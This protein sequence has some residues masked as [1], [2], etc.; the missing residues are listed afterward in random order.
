MKNLSWSRIGGWAR[1]FLLNKYVVVVLIFLPV[2]LFVGEQSLVNMCKR[3]VQIRRLERQLQ[4][5]NEEKARCRR[6][7]NTMTSTD[8]LERYA[9]EHYYMHAP[10][11]DVY[12]VSDR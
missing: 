5:K 10:E 9:R 2:F 1:W 6:A 11:E 7:L 4:S 3:S 12:L 8:S